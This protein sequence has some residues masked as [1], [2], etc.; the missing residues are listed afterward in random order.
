M[1][2]GIGGHT[3][4]NKGATDSWITPKKIIEAIGPFDLDPCECTPQPWPCAAK[5][6]TAKDDGLSLPWAGRVWLNPPYSTA[7]KWLDRLASHGNGTALV[8]ARTETE[9]FRRHVWDRAHG[10]LF[11]F[12]RLYFH[13][14]DGT[15]AKGNSGGPS[16]LVAYSHKDAERLKACKLHGA[17][18]RWTRK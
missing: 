11:L 7:E 18:C 13:Y 15:R 17:F 2:R 1:P 6:Y 3:L 5:S 9:M 8:F 12:G 14:P 4:P 10:L 16:V